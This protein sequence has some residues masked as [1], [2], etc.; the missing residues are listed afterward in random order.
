MESNRKQENRADFVRV[1]LAL[2]LLALMAAFDGTGS[3]RTVPVAQAD[4]AAR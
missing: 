1:L 4:S 3:S 2:V